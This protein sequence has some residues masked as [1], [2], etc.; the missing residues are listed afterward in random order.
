M[1]NIKNA[2]WR[3]LVKAQLCETWRCSPAAWERKPALWLGDRRWITVLTLD[4]GTSLFAWL[5]GLCAHPRSVNLCCLLCLRIIIAVLGYRLSGD[6]QKLFFF[7]LVGLFFGFL[8]ILW[9]LVQVGGIFLIFF[10]F[11][12]N[13][14]TVI[15]PLQFL[16]WLCFEPITCF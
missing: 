6:G 12:V 5:K 7:L 10:H 15:Y 13:T 1:L 2:E 16:L 9:I 14:I 3:G 8:F 11:K 4:F